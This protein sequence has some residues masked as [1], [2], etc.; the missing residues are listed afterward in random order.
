MP[1]SARIVILDEPV[2][3]HLV[4][5]TALGGISNGDEEK[6]FLVERIRRM[7]KVYFIEIY[8]F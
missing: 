2:V 7:S 6:D 8:G 3:Y 1:R 5:R 4:S